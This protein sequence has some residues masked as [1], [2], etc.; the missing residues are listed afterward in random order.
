MATVF[1]YGRKDRRFDPRIPHYSSLL[2]MKGIVSAASSPIPAS[3]DWAS[4]MPNSLG[5]LLNDQ[6]GDCTCAATLH[7]KQ[8]WSFNVD[9]TMA[10][11]VDSEALWEYENWAGY[12]NGDPSTDNGADEQTILTD[13]LKQGILLSDG[14]HDHLT[15]FVELDVRNLNDV[16]RAIYESGLVYIGFNVPQSIENDMQAGGVP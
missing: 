7:A 13:W 2:Q 6:L 3:H 14:T 8:V 11:V 1:K 10:T 9:P 16:R 12:V 5:Y 15:A 4:K